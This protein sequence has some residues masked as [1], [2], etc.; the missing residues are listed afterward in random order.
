MS[1]P[2]LIEQPAVGEGEPGVDSGPKHA[3]NEAVRICFDES[4]LVH[5]ALMIC[6]F[7]G[8]GLLMILAHFIPESWGIAGLGVCFFAAPFCYLVGASLVYW[9]SI[10]LARRQGRLGGRADRGGEDGE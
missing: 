6:P 8:T 9:P 2:R 1:R 7:T 3:P 10:T 4:D 5:A